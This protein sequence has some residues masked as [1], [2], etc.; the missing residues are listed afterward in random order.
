VLTVERQLVDNG[1]SSFWSFC[2]DFLVPGA[3]P[4][5]AASTR[6][7]GAKAKVD[8]REVLQPDEFAVYA[9][10]RDLRKE[11][12]VKES[13]PVYMIFSNEQLAQMV[14]GRAASKADLECRGR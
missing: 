8:Y 3:E 7:A 12:S 10:L 6:P 11:L 2:V 4:A 1:P 14:Q 9:R 13:V 5:G